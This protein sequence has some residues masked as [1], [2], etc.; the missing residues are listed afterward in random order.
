MT[1][2]GG[3]LA[4][5]FTGKAKRRQEHALTYR[6]A[7]L[8][9]QP[10]PA[11]CQKDFA[12]AIAGEKLY[13]GDLEQVLQRINAL[14]CLGFGRFHAQNERIN[15]LLLSLF[16]TGT[17][18]N[19]GRLKAELDQVVNRKGPRAGRRVAPPRAFA[20]RPKQPERRPEF[21]FT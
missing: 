14:K 10:H 4:H 16:N 5:R 19:H 13:L 2:P 1:K 12:A 3:T 17:A 6:P 11:R 18:Y 8:R 9:A 20:C 7:L 21:S 15:K